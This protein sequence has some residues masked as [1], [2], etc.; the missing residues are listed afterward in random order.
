MENL[1]L[2]SHLRSIS[3]IGRL[4]SSIEL[5]IAS[6]AQA[7][8]V[9]RKEEKSFKEFLSESISKVNGQMVTADQ[10]I[11]DLAT[12]RSGDIHTTMIEMQKA[13][14]AF[15]TLLEVRNKISRSYEDVM[16]MQA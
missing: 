3:G 1:E 13:D 9:A 5:P 4:Q 12:G 11:D 15:K 8:A 2:N 6:T 10:K 14:I 7:G 16:R